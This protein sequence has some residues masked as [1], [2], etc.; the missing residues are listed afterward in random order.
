MCNAM[1]GTEITLECSFV[2]PA[3]A[4]DLAKRVTAKIPVVDGKLNGCEV[5]VLRDTGC[6]TIVVNRSFVKDDELTGRTIV[7]VMIDG[8]AKEY[9]AAMVNIEAPFLNGSVEAVCMDQPLYDVI[10]A[11]RPRVRY[12]MD[13]TWV[14]TCEELP[15]VVEAQAVVTRGHAQK[16]GRVKPL[17]VAESID[18]NLTT[19]EITEMQKQD[20]S[21]SKAESAR[22]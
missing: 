13:V 6:S 8:T 12:H 18:C 7:C 17:K 14:A 19:A 2:A 5:K 20:K 21:L 1:I 3:L 10:I 16:D 15:E 4:C 11:N 9:P 22:S